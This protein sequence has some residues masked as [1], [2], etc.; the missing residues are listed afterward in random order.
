MTKNE[1]TPEFNKQQNRNNTFNP[2]KKMTQF[3][4]E[5]SEID[6]IIARINFKNDFRVFLLAKT[7]PK[8][9]KFNWRI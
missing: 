5:K 7:N 4:K 2:V 1:T 8:T 3:H 6:K 9:T